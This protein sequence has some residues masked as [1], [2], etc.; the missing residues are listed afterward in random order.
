MALPNGELKHR[1][2]KLVNGDAL[3]ALEQGWLH[4][5][6]SLQ[7]RKIQSP[8]RTRLN[9]HHLSLGDI[10]PTSTSS[11]S[12]HT[13]ARVPSRKA[14]ILSIDGGRIRGII[15]ATLVLCYLEQTLQ[16]K[17]G[18]S[19]A[20]IA[21]F[22]D[23]VA[24]SSVGGLIATMLCTND[25]NGRPLFSAIEANKLI[26][27]ECKDSMFKISPIHPPTTCPKLCGLLT[28][29]RRCRRYSTDDFERILMRYLVRG[30]R[31]LT[32]R[33]TIRPILIP[34][35]DMSSAGAFLFSRAD[36]MRCESF[37]FTLAE[38]CRATTAVPG[39]FKPAKMSSVDGKTSVVGIDG[40]LVMNNPAATAITHVLH[41]TEEFPHVLDVGDTLV[42]S[43][44]AG[45][46]EERRYG[47]EEVIRWGPLEWAQPLAHIVLD[48]HS[49]MVDH[50]M[51][52]A[53]RDHRN[54][55]V[56]IQVSGVA[57]GG[58]G[59]EELSSIAEELLA[60]PCME[61]IPFGGKR[62]LAVSNRER[63]DWFA[64]CLVAEQ[65]ARAA[66]ATQAAAFPLTASTGTPGRPFTFAP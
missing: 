34:C 13:P 3:A 62:Q 30:Q 64:D 8:V 14:C 49:D 46:G 41:N 17:S 33:D 15:P 2:I 50:F 7:L 25:G 12:F 39:M 56:R 38:V 9:F 42:L 43:L 26:T 31:K 53:F 63:L 54:N 10:S 21:D 19:N 20:R 52:M 45:L 6:E 5:K 60:K 18:N 16:K 24:G 4:Y 57:R 61:H 35:Y 28:R 55:Y 47:H 51:S 66:A 44:G 29:H 37:D 11:F 65:R 40:G 58:R 1:N 32:L 22:F 23:I 36:A 59:K 48:G 27:E